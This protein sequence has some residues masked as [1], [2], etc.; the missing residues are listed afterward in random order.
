[1]SEDYSQKIGQAAGAVYH[2]LENGERNLTQLKKC[3]LE[4]GFDSQ[5]SAMAIGW[6]AREDKIYISKKASKWSIGLK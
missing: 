3:L 2:E 5:T 1:M 6:L 4:T